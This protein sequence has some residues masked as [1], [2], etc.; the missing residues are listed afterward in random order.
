MEEKKVLGFNKFHSNKSNRD[1]LV[2]HCVSKASGSD[3][4]R[5]YVGQEK[6][7]EIY[8]PDNCWHLFTEQICGKTCNFH[9]EI[10]GRYVNLVNITLK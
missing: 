5:G 10:N 7:E 8:I 4:N 1:F 3:V 6:V 2:A 9:Y